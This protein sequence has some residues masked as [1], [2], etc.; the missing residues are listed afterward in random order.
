MKK[1]KD[2]GLKLTPQRLAILDFLEGNTNHPS[3]EDI[4]KAL[5]ENFPTMS[6]ATVYNTLDSLKNKGRILELSIDPEKK[7]FDPN[8]EPHN[9]LICIKCKRVADIQKTFDLGLAGSQI[10]DFEILGHHIEFYGICPACKR[11][12]DA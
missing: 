2:I 6:L 1:Y 5:S 8:T 11:V 12:T 9:H 7:R 3:A 4:Y 10:S